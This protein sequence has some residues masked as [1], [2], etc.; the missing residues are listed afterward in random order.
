[1]PQ[2]AYQLENASCLRLSN[3]KFN[4]NVILEVLNI[5]EA[6]MNNIK[7]TIEVNAYLCII[8]NM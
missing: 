2:I 4:A 8:H 7:D 6:M 1:M 5:T 3:I